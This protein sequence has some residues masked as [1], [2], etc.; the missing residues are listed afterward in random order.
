MTMAPEKLQENILSSTG[1]EGGGISDAVPNGERPVFP[2][3]ASEDLE[4]WNSTKT[5]VYR[6]FAT[7][8][9]FIILGMSDAAYGA[10]IPYHSLILEGKT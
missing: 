10:L 9:S 3:S 5:N 6:Y 4:K 8:Y 1:L 7:L 2:A